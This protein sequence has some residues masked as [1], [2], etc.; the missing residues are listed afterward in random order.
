MVLSPN[1]FFFI[2]QKKARNII[3]KLLHLPPLLSIKLT[4]GEILNIVTN[5]FGNYIH[6]ATKLSVDVVWFMFSIFYSYQSI[7]GLM[8]LLSLKYF[9]LLSLQRALILSTVSVWQLPSCC[10]KTNSSAYLLRCFV[11]KL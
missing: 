4:F 8:R 1:L 11:E 5:I 9:P 7:E 10:L 6:N 2:E 3:N